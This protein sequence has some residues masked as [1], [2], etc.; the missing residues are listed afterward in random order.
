MRER[1]YFNVLVN[2]NAE[3]TQGKQKN[4]TVEQAYVGSSNS[5]G[6]SQ[7]I[8]S[9]PTSRPSI[10]DANNWSQ[11]KKQ[12]SREARKIALLGDS[13]F[14]GIYLNEMEKYIN[15]ADIVVAAYPGAT[16]KHL[17]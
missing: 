15:N 2:E 16:A 4:A 13:H 1:S 11:D 6:N 3:M 7:Q 5:G 14:C 12:S 17:R 10:R 9:T 8:N